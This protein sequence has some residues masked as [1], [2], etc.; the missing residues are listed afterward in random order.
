MP[1]T[2][3]LTL[4]KG[5]MHALRSG[6]KMS[7]P[8]AAGEEEGTKTPPLVTWDRKNESFPTH[9]ILPRF[10]MRFGIRKV[11]ILKESSSSPSSNVGEIGLTHFHSRPPL[12]RQ[13]HLMNDE[14]LKFK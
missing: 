11:A 9:W 2:T 10:T 8:S 4:T 1:R 14:N 6:D 3:N 7:R 13:T 12:K 5:V